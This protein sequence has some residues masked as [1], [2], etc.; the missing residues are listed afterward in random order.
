[1]AS[2]QRNHR[3]LAGFIDQ[4]FQQEADLMDKKARLAAL[5]QELTAEG[6]PVVSPQVIEANEI[7]VGSDPAGEAEGLLEEKQEQ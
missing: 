1:L 5:I 3:N 7:G 6:S 2:L 4:P